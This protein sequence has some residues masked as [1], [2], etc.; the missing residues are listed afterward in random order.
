MRI[1]DRT[2]RAWLAAPFGRRHWRALQNLRRVRP[3]GQFLW[4]Y[5]SQTGTYPWRPLVRTP[6][7][8]LQPLLRSRHDLLTLHEV[9]LREDYRIG[10]EPVRVLD[11]G[12]N[13]GLAALYWLSRSPEVRLL[14]Y[15]PDPA[16]LVVLEENLRPF[17]GRY[18]VLE[19]AVWTES[20]TLRFQTESTG[21]YGHLDSEGKATVEAHGPDQVLDLCTEF[22]GPRGADLIKIDIEGHEEQLVAAFATRGVSAA[23]VYETPRGVRRRRGLQLSQAYR[24]GYPA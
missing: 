5:L 4:R 8:T 17:R 9:L 22:F 20:G 18:R 6:L 24:D 19:A 14:C 2:L 3:A 1:R 10:G 15:E 13:I 7:G 23:I 11:I 12:A 21:R 16:N